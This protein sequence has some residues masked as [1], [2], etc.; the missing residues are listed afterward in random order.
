VSGSKGIQAM[1]RIFRMGSFE[2]SAYQVFIHTVMLL[3]VITAIFPLVYLL[4][5]SI[6]SKAEIVQRQYFVVIPRYPTLEAYRRILASPVLWQGFGISLLRSTVGPLATITT[7]LLGAFVLSRRSLPGRG[8]LLFIIV[9]TIVMGSGLVP[10]YLVIKQLGMINTFSVMI[11]PGL[12][13]SFG[14]L[15]I[16]VFIEGLPDELIDAARIDGASELQL[17]AWVVTPLAAPA[18]AAIFMFS[19]VGHW[20]SW[21][22]ALVFIKNA[23]LQPVQ[24]V[25]RGFLVS[26]IGSSTADTFFQT[27]GQGMLRQVDTVTIRY[28]S[29]VLATIPILCVYPFVQKYFTK[30]VYMGALKG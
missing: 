5:M 23:N 17:L 27:E 1:F 19:V 3:V 15:I 26:S 21:F 2:E 28:A 18:L 30:G 20:N 9:F 10:F 4:G 22:D 7:T 6:T 29:V 14:L 13:D 16:K 24:L 11:L 8:F 25:I 12:V